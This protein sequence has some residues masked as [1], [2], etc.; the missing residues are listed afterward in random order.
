MAVM[1]REQSYAPNET[2][3][4][5]GQT[6]DLSRINTELLAFVV[7]VLLSIIAHFYGLGKM[8]LHHDESIHAWMSW[9]LFTGVGGFTCYGG[10]LAATYCYEPTYHGPSLYIFTTLSYFLFGDG[11]WQARIPQA[12]AGIGMVASAWMLRPYLGTK[13][14]LVAAVLMGFSPSLLYYTRFA[15]HDGLILLWTLWMVIGF[16]RFIDTGRAAYLVLLMAGASLAIAT[17]ELYYILF[18]VFGWFLIVRIAFEQLPRRTVDIALIVLL[19]I[20][21]G[22]ELWNPRITPSV[23]AGG[24]ALLFMTVAATGLFMNRVWD[25]QPIISRCL[26]ELFTKR[27]PVFWGAFAVFWAIYIL[28]Y[29]TF[30]ADPQSL[31]TGLYAGLAYWLGSQQEFARGDQP[32]YYHLM[33]LA[34]YEPLALF[35]GIGAAI[36]MYTRGFTT[37]FRTQ[38]APAATPVADQP[39]STEPSTGATTTLA[40]EPNEPNEPA[41]TTAAEVA[42]PPHPRAILNLFPLFLAFWFFG[43]LVA[44][45][46]AGEKMPWL[47]THIALPGNLLVAW[48]IGR[49]LDAIDWGTLRDRSVA[50][51]PPF[52]TIMLI[53]FGVAYWRIST[54]GEGQQAQAGLLQGLVPLAVGGALL[55]AILTIGQRIG[56]RATAAAA[57]LTLSALLGIY[58][59]RA[60]WTVVYIQPDTP[61]EPL[62]Y[63]QSSPDV[64]LIVRNVRELA[65]NQTRNVRNETDP[66]GGLTMPVIMDAGDPNQGGE[67][68]LAW[69]Y[70]WYLRD[71]KRLE[72]RD[73][74]FFRNATPESFIVDPVQPGADR[75]LAPVVLVSKGSLSE[76]GRAALEAGYVKRFDSK[77]NWWF[78]EGNK[79]DPDTLGYKRFYYS[80]MMLADAFK[81]CP[82]IDS[83]KIQ[84]VF[85][86]ILWPLDGSH[87][88]STWRFLLYRQ[89]PDGLRLDGR[90]MEVWVRSDL[91]PTGASSATSSGPLKLVATETFGQA[92]N[93]VGQ[94]G[95]AS[96]ITTDTQGN[97]YVADTLNHRIQ[98]FAAD[99]SLLRTIGEFGSGDGQ[100]NEPRGV[101]V[102]R[103][104][105]IYVADT[106]NARVAKFDAQGNFLLSWGSGREDFGAGRRAS[107][108]DGTLAG[109]A[110]EPL[111]F[112]GPRGIAVDDAGNVYLAD[113]GNKRVVVTDSEGNFRYQFGEFGSGPGQF[114]EPI[115]IAVD[116]STVYVADTW[117]GRVQVFI[118]EGTGQVSP[119]PIGTWRVAG[120]QP[121]TYDDPFISA[122]GGQVVVSVPGRNAA[123]LYNPSGTE[124]LRW[125]GSGEDLASL[126]LPSGLSF[127]PDGSVVVMDRGN[128]RVMRFTLPITR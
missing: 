33:L 2:G 86:P 109:N 105:N 74:N 104:G 29:S 103:A 70:Q 38:T 118:R 89:L 12:V 112:F 23:R 57:G 28:M 117:N 22:V 14:A 128:N 11:D 123:V 25:P 46:W 69:P 56:W 122:Q 110:A 48:A 19:V 17:H 24:M 67:G 68:S 61:V 31:L 78:P 93:Q 71:F 85:A 75:E 21:F 121:Q 99:G 87:W 64:P 65:I 58:M 101:A 62:V 1:P 97:V 95:G 13:G 73:S 44:F 59:L 45:S 94:F 90:E 66:I 52:L 39:E 16:F 108:T 35:G 4:L 92:G 100:F 127:A 84:N 27:M 51:V 6:L 124:L 54:P 111:G 82:N 116:G 50:L 79:C 36:Y 119:N 18:F 106:W 76:N 8:A 10:R 55:Y 30:F 32:W 34:I 80:T 98:V 7:V 88:D 63:V 43:N 81:D 72:S 41:A 47:V 125:G 5:L 9:K 53:A 115:G 96:A 120:W 40:S 26:A 126:R 60:S 107:P 20:A 42:E 83:T 114:S 77:L 102:D 113:T 49:M 91:A 15:R 37:A 3:G